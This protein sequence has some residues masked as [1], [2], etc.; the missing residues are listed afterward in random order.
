M[1]KGTWNSLAQEDRDAIR[2]AA[3]ASYQSLGSVMD[4]HF[5]AQLEDL[6]KAGATVRIL[7]RHEPGRFATVAKY[8][9]VQATWVAD[10]KNKG[11]DSA[12]P[13]MSAVAAIMDEF[14]G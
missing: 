5:D 2:R 9:E 13:A 6:K 11:V 4:K 10:Q 8:R 12:G 14:L 3:Q 1:N 7:D